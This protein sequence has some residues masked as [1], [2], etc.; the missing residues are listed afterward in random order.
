M[1]FLL[2]LGYESRYLTRMTNDILAQAL[3]WDILSSL[4]HDW[5]L[6]RTTKISPVLLAYLSSRYITLKIMLSMVPDLLNQD[7]CTCCGIHVSFGKK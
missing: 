1:S 7:M 6:I 4:P 3:L 2:P 5:K